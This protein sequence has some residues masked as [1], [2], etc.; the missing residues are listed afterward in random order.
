MN[1][2][3]PILLFDGVCNLCNGLVT[4]IIR[5]DHGAKIKFAHLQ[6]HSGQMLL[7]QFSLVSDDIDSVVYIVENKYF[8][9]SSAVLQVFKDLGRGWNMLYSFII[10]PEFI[11]DFF[12]NLI[13]RNRYKI[14][15]KK[16]SCRIPEPGKI[17]RFL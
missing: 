3:G 4:F 16:D 10:I 13:A 5:K 9:R 8:L 1:T 12:Y 2:P 11:R 15:G 17:E 6:S 7:K 14:F